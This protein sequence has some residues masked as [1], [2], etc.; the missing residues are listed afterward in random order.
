MNLS[1]HDTSAWP[2]LQNYAE[3]E[4][5]LFAPFAFFSSQSAGR[6]VKEVDRPYRGPFQRDRDRILH[7][8]AYR[9]LSGKMQVFTGDRG[10]YHRNRLTHTIEVACI[11]R[12][13]G[14]ALRLNEDLIEALTLLHD[15]GHPPF[16][17]A[18][19]DALAECLAADGGFSHNRHALT[20]VEELEERYP[21]F[22]G[23][24]LTREVLDG[25]T[26]R[27]DK[28][29]ATKVGLL[30]VQ[31]V[32][33]SDWL[34]YSAHDVDDAV[35]LG[36][37]TIPELAAIPLVR[38]TLGEIRSACGELPPDVLRKTL[39]HELIDRQVS[40]VLLSTGP[41]L[42]NAAPKSAADVILRGLRIVVSP[43]MA[44]HQKELQS[45]LYDR[46][47]RHA[48]LMRVRRDAQLQIRRLFEALVKSPRKMPERF[49]RR[50][51]SVGIR[52]AVGE[53]IAGM[54]DRFCVQQFEE[55]GQ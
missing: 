32:E 28:R 33:T 16:G 3:R 43:A 19:E 49:L 47:Y 55:L 44:R 25:Q 31:V 23:L 35:K 51:E 34:T 20:I 11:A 40:D 7:C 17:H 14:R 54:T 42:A 38:E 12:T 2:G 45:F 8:S 48:D 24:N 36:L 22:P 50:I 30:E 18:G 27:I 13:I 10:D 1:P 37:V 9:R 52:R 26:T 53:Y 5:A 39:V 41:A 21:Q 46:V 4:A 6:K 29:A 15:L